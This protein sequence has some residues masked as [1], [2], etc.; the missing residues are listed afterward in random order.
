MGSAKSKYPGAAAKREVLIRAHD[1][2]GVTE[3]SW[4]PGATTDFIDL[5]FPLPDDML[6]GNEVGLKVLWSCE[7]T[8]TADKVTW[9]ALYN[10]LTNDT[11]S[12]V[13]APATALSTVIA[14]DTNI[15]TADAIQTTARG[16]LNAA[17]TAAM[18]AGV[19]FLKFRINANAVTSLTLG[20]DKVD[21]LGLIIDYVPRYI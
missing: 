19:D 18:V 5:L 17:V 16:I 11:T 6:V 21:F 3:G 13:T 7:T 2:S 14:E 20:T 12:I 15:G 8:S 1:F 9:R 4:V 10:K